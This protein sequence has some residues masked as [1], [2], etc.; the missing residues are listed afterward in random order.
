[1]SSTTFFNNGVMLLVLTMATPSVISASSLRPFSRFRR[2]AWSSCN[3]LCGLP[4]RRE[5]CGDGSIGFSSIGV[6]KTASP[7]APTG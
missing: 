5:S 2:F 4:R 1:M 3:S 7:C 6:S